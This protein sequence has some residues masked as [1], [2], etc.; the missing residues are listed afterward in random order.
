MSI[1]IQGIDLGFMKRWLGFSIVAGF[2]IPFFYYPQGYTSLEGLSRIWDDMVY[3]FLISLMISG[4]VG[5]VEV[6][7][8]HYVPWI[9]SPVKRLIL[10]FLGV[11]LL[12]FLSVFIIT[13]LFLWVFGRFTLDNI[14]WRELIEYTKVP[15]YI[16]Y[17]IT[18]FFLSRA[19]LKEWRN[20]AV[21]VERLETE[22]YKGQVRLLKDQLNP[23]FLFNSFNVLIDVVY[24][25]QDKA[26]AYIRELSKFY[27]HILEVQDED[28]VPLS[29][30]LEFTKRYTSL[31]QMRFGKALVLT[32]KINAQKEEE[33]PPLVLQLLVENAIKHNQAE[34]GKPLVI[35][36]SVTDE[37]ILVA[38]NLNP[39][40]SIEEG[41]G[42]GLEN[43]RKRYQM[44]TNR[45]VVIN[46]NKQHFMVKLPRLF[47]KSLSE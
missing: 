12:G 24:E 19:F 11:T 32:L 39:K 28:L 13:F 15:M 37:Y 47:P 14:P 16:G 21:N 43:I 44:L 8:N 4:S 45:E 29:E 34:K 20:A 3:S 9:K 23:H 1:K 36:M 17:G 41:M 25:D 30:E 42:I 38:N 5:L 27:R 35:T 26:A 22:K 10:E 33:I 6:N 40:G 7:L 2:M 46:K 31:Q 18:A